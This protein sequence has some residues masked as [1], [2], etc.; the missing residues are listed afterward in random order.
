M[1]GGSDSL[2]LEKLLVDFDNLLKSY[3]QSIL[4]YIEYLNSVSGKKKTGECSAVGNAKYN[5]YCQASSSESS[6]CSS[7][8]RTYV[9]GFGYMC[10][11]S[12]CC[13]TS[14]YDDYILLGIS[15]ENKLVKRDTQTSEWVVVD[16]GDIRDDLIALCTGNDGKMV[17]GVT[18][19]NSFYYKL[20]YDK[21]WLPP[22]HPCC[23]MSVAMGQDGTLVGVGMGNTLWSKPSLNSEPDLDALWI[24][25]RS[26]DQIGL[27]SICIAPN[28]NFFAVNNQ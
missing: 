4:D 5:S 18:T 8:C 24:D 28:G 13:G 20:E 23:I 14:S 19:G 10:C 17:I 6:T 7:Q 11:S 25:S 12:G 22:S 15:D 27:R 21:E 1:G 16:D 9:S 3:N 26:P 2:E